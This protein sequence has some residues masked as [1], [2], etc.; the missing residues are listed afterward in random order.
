MADTIKIR[1]TIHVTS[2][3]CLLG[4]LY[5]LV[6]M[7]FID[8]WL[9][10]DQVHG[11]IA[12]IAVPFLLAFVCGAAGV[13]VFATYYWKSLRTIDLLAALSPTLFLGAYFLWAVVWPALQAPRMR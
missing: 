8:G 10:I 12:I 2:C 4:I 11:S 1:R 7:M 6:V 3:V 13:L 9:G 5:S